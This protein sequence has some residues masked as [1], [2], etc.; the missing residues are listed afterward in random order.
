L[1]DGILEIM[2]FVEMVS[3]E[4]TDFCEKRF[5]ARL[6]AGES[7]HDIKKVLLEESLDLIGV[8]FFSELVELLL[9]FDVERD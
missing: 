3:V 2:F 4:S 6:I 1:F 5:V 9:A 7:V 8:L